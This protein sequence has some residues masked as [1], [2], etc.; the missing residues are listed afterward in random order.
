MKERIKSAA[1]FLLIVLSIL[2]TGMLWYSSPSYQENKP[3]YI[4][5]PLIGNEQYNQIPLH[6]RVASVPVIVHRDGQQG[7]ILPNEPAHRDFLNRLYKASWDDPEPVVPRPEE[8][9]HLYQKAAGVELQFINDLPADAIDVMNE[10]EISAS[11][12]NL[13]SRIWIRS[14]SR[15]QNVRLWLISDRERKVLESE[16]DFPD[17]SKWFQEMER[18][19]QP[20]KP[21][22]V[23]GKIPLD[24]EKDEKIS[25]FPLA[26]YL[27]DLPPTVRS[28][29][30]PLKQIKVEDIK[31]LF[32]DPN[33]IWTLP[34][35]EGDTYTDGNRMLQHNQQKQTVVYRDLRAE[36]Q[37]SSAAIELEILNQF[38]KT[39]N[40][41]TGS[42]SLDRRIKEDHIHLYIFRLTVGG[43]PVYWSGEEDKEEV[44]PDTIR[45]KVSSDRVAE[46]HRSLRYLS[47][48]PSDSRDALLPG[49]DTVI[50]EL[51]DRGLS[52]NQL[53]RL[54]PGYQVKML[55]DHV[56]LSPVWI[57]LK[58]N[59]ESILL[60]P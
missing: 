16:I 44:R 51:A 40:G 49:R 25:A 15:G 37:P 41:W 20:V 53:R 36:P 22:F 33:Q 39:H 5:P 54:I 32:T 46:Y 52:L 45:L 21:H 6:E 26:V 58:K 19:A 31:W 7:W 60:N 3:S 12:I 43:L 50:R 17:F 4:Q 56:R 18:K 30:Y 42:Y 47:S 57:A 29:T 24:E 59:G 14:D 38:M 23:T 10:E 34:S 28:F 35:E 11:G 8:W 48:K 2:Q 9:N 55:K 27:P 13:I 1:L